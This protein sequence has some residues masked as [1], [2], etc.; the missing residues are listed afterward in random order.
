MIC[1]KIITCLHWRL[2]CLGGSDFLLETKELLPIFMGLKQF[3]F[4]FEKK[5]SKMA[6]SK[7]LS[8]S[9]SPILKKKL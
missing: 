3:F 2:K 5:K 8:F 9:K 4:F 1:H 7:K 6:D